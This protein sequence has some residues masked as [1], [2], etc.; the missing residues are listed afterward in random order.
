MFIL[1][2]KVQL[3]LRCSIAALLVTLLSGC[4]SSDYSK[5][6]EFFREGKYHSAVE[7]Y[8]SFIREHPK[9]SKV[10][11]SL[12]KMG[13]ITYQ[14]IGETKKGLR[15]FNNLVDNYPIDKFTILAQ[16]RIAEI[17][18]G[19]LNDCNRAIVEFQKLIDWD[20]SSSRAPYFLYQIGSCYMQLRNYPQALIE[21]ES[22]LSR[23]PKSEYIGDTLYQIGNIYYINGDYAKATTYYDMVI[24]SH[25]ESKYLPQAKFGLASCYEEMEDFDKALKAYGELLNVYPSKKVV[26]IRIEGVKERKKKLNR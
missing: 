3:T 8:Y 10:T 4:I 13:D 22:V 2:K 20:R 24:T 16:Q 15:Y 26:E 1:P 7:M 11:E 14:Y 23:Y 6:E 21:F 17:Y 12:F 18:K 5:A 9:S 25:S 19:K